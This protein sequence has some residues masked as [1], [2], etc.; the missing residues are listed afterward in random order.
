MTFVRALTRRSG[1]R[2]ITIAGLVAAGAL[3]AGCRGAP[4]P[5][6]PSTLPV[7]LAVAYADSRLTDKPGS[8]IATLVS[9]LTTERLLTIARDGRL[10]P[11]LAVPT[12]SADGMTWTFDL[13]PKLKFHD[14]TLVTAPVVAEALRNWIQSD[15]PISPGMRDVERIDAVDDRTFVVHMR[16]PSTLFPEA[17]GFIPIVSPTPAGQDGLAAPANGSGAFKLVSQRPGGATLEA[18]AEY[19]GGR[20]LIDE[21]DIRLYPNSR[22]AWGAL[23]R[24]E[25]DFLY[26]VA[27]EAQ[28]FVERQSTTQ[29]K[30]FLRPYV[31]AMGFNIRHPQ[32]RNRNVRVALNLAVNRGDLLDVALHSHGS[33]AASHVWPRHWA[34][35]HALPR[36]AF[37]P[38]QASQMLD[39]EGLVVPRHTRGHTPNRFSFTCLLPA[40]DMRFERM[41]LMLQRQLIEVGV[42]MR[43]EV[44]EP[45]QLAQRLSSGQFD[46]FLFELASGQV[47]DW[48]YWFWHSG[49]EHRPWVNTGYRGADAALDRIRGALTDAEMKAAVHEL[50]K[51]FA[52][53]PPAVFL[54]WSETARAVNRRFEVPP[55]SDRDIFST[56]T[57]W[58]IAAAG[59]ESSP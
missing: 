16:R 13:R 4:P 1:A 6:Q 51:V 12:R 37:A 31:Y 36:P 8:G 53:D 38:G 27:P 34:Y 59:P 50:Q 40:G 21:V 11:N 42:D 19:H 55:T 14:G 57:Q 29:V 3:L 46:A 25:I 32:L 52:E 54:C 45:Q 22:N 35:D 49:R 17:L 26:D 28:E 47:F 18:F 7:R 48:V 24:G 56:L 30:P 43:L 15:P 58:R 23:M 44:L 10:E 41:A 39:A 20:P 33:T 9:F 5:R 2:V